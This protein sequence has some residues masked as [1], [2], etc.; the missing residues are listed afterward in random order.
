MGSCVLMFMPE[1]DP[2]LGNPLMWMHFL[3]RGTLQGDG[4]KRG[5]GGEG[6]TFIGLRVFRVLPKENCTST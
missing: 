5:A 1:G 6:K 2:R 3:W 4:A